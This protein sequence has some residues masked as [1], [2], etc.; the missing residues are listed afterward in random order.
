MRKNKIYQIGMGAI[1]LLVGVQLATAGVAK[2]AK[3][4]EK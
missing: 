4:V 2:I 3:V 1:W